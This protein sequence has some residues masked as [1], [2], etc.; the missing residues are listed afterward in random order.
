MNVQQLV[1]GEQR[2]AD[3]RTE[4]AHHDRLRIDPSDQSTC[5]LVVYALRLLQRYPQPARELGDRRRGQTP[6]TATRTVW[7]RQHQRR[8]MSV[9][10]RQTFEDIRGELGCAEKDRAQ[11]CPADRR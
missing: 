5:V 6:A 7:A 3:E 9:A 11:V 4:R 1:L 8:T 2:L 10:R